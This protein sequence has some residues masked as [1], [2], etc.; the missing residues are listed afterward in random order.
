MSKVTFYYTRKKEMVL[1]KGC[2]KLT[3]AHITRR[4]KWK[5]GGGGGGGGLLMLRQN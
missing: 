4:G 5:G 1:S 3:L 2:C